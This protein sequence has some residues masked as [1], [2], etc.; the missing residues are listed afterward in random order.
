[1]LSS[2]SARLRLHGVLCLKLCFHYSSDGAARQY[3][4]NRAADSVVL[5][6]ATKII[7]WLAN[8]QWQ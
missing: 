2:L 8:W 4:G 1:R 7:L 6:A 5:A 3:N